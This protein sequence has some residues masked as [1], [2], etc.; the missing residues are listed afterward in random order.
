M[1]IDELAEMLGRAT[2]D[3]VLEI[4]ATNVAEESD[5]GIRSSSSVGW[6]GGQGGVVTVESRKMRVDRPG[7][8]A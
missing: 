5:Q 2:I 4:S 7:L 6:H 3:A 1:E 8:G